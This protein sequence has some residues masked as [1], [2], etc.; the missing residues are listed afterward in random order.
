MKPLPGATLPSP[1]AYPFNRMR[2]SRLTRG[3]TGGELGLLREIR[4]QALRQGGSS[5]RLGIG[6]D[7]ALT[8][9]GGGIA[10]PD[11]CEGGVRCEAGGDVN[12]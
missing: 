4:A 9:A 8:D 11:C 7:C 3:T 2:A 5:L 10:P 1:L 12:R 6:D